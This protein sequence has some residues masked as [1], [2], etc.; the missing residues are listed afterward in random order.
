M[1]KIR[2]AVCLT[3]LVGASA[4]AQIS[5]PAIAANLGQTAVVATPA[6]QLTVMTYNVKGLPWPLAQ[7]RPAA[8]AAIGQ[9]LKQLRQLGA[10]PHVVVL[11]EAFTPAAK[12][13]ARIAGYRFV[14]IG[15]RP[16]DSRSEETAALGREFVENASWTK[17]ETEGTWV[18]SG[19]V[20]LS[21]YPIE[22]T[23]KMAFPMAACAGFDCLASKGV[24]IT[25][26]KLGDGGEPIAIVNTHL[27][28]RGAS[29]VPIERSNSAYARQ[30]DSLAKFIGDNVGIGTSVILSGDLNVGTDP[31]RRLKL[32]QAQASLDF[33]D[34]ALRTLV[35]K[36]A[37]DLSSTKDLAA[38]IKRSKDMQFFRSGLGSSLR[39]SLVSV[40]FGTDEDGS[41]LSDH[42]GFVVSYSL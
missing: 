33:S 31:S 15:P 24:L 30:F 13:I 36:K 23:V 20:T 27:N 18:D 35:S 16:I 12:E 14:A 22:K 37:F 11:Q 8:L 29:G 10:Q 6:D 21:D 3:I 7:G 4:P 26:I 42:M 17:G 40:P 28:S 19:L 9:K 1:R 39:P 25:W 32:T 38:I 5:R 2:L 41:M 34:E